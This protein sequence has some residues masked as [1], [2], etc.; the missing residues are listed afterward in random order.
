MFKQQTILLNQL[1]SFT[2]NYYEQGTNVSLTDC[3]HVPWTPYRRVLLE[4]LSDFQ[5]VKKFPAFHATQRF[6]T[7]FKTACHQYLSCTRSIALGCCSSLYSFPAVKS[8]CL[9]VVVTL[10]VTN[11]LGWVAYV[12][13]WG[14]HKQATRGKPSAM[15]LTTVNSTPLV[16]PQYSAIFSYY[17]LIYY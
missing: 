13:G 17:G 12:R 15:L 16:H 10:L 7:M 5:L 6:I 8:F 4:K 14:K 11:T 1:H 2:S 3:L 9:Q